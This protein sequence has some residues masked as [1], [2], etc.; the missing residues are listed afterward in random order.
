MELHCIELIEE[1]EGIVN[2]GKKSLVGNRVSIDKEALLLLLGQLKDI[3]P[4]ELVHANDFYQ[5]SRECRD[6]AEED[7][8]RI[9]EQANR[10]A[11]EIT[12]KAQNDAELIIEEARSEA[13]AIVTEAMEE[14]AQMVSD[15]QIT[16]LANERAEQI[17]LQA[18]K[19]ASD[20]KKATTK[21]LDERL[22]YVADVLGRTYHE[23]EDNRK[24]L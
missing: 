20:I 12:V 4:T 7:A 19:K 14:Q 15:H 3:L 16:L 23:I 11:N 21:Y 1:I 2:S 9:I 13:N 18:G 10:E 5:D 6:E 22:S 17:V 8:D 24:S